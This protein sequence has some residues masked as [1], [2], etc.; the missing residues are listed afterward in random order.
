MPNPIDLPRIA[1]LRDI[2]DDYSAI[3]SDVW[4]VIHNG[5]RAHK[6]AVE[7]LARFRQTRGPVVMITN[8]PRPWR[9]VQ[10]L[11]R[12]FAIPDETYDAIITSGD[13]TASM[14]RAHEGDKVY[15]LGPDRDLPMFDGIA[16][17]RVGPEAADFVLCTGLFDDERETM[18]DYVERLGELRRRNLTMICAN[19]DLVVE[20]GH[21]LVY[22]AGS[23][24]QLY[25]QLGGA[26]IY[27]G[28]PHGPVYQRAL[29][30]IAAHAGRPIDPGDVLAIGDSIKTDLA[31]AAHAGMLS[32]FIAGGIHNEEHPEGRGLADAF[33]K[34][35]V[36]PRAVM[37]QLA[38]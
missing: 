37:E 5:V 11:L 27:A 31:G 1:G 32:L 20:R 6:M 3:L 29:E 8:A 25:E 35:D 22:C 10:R 26:V 16:V 28:K 4:G 33:A 34:A 30:E 21:R 9:D 12:E 23:V 14:L 7:A 24:A 2:A 38:W 18:D 15:H 36:S 13:L 17:E 19:P